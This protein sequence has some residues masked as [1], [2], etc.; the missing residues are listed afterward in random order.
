MVFPSAVPPNCADAKPI[1][2]PIEAIPDAPVSAIIFATTAST[3]VSLNCAGKNFSITAI[4]AN[5][6]S[7][8]SIRFC[9][10]KILALSLRDFT[11]F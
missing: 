8:K 9:S 10:V 2:L 1:T 4:C 5:S 3:S 7:A 6:G 11:N